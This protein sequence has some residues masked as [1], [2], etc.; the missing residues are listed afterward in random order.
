MNHSS[1]DHTASRSGPWEALLAASSDGIILLDA[2]GRV[3][4]ASPVALR[5]LGD[6]L[7][8]AYA[9]SILPPAA[10]AADGPARLQLGCTDVVVHH[11]ALGA[12]GAMLLIQIAPQS[13]ASIS[14]GHYEQK[15]YDLLM[16]ISS[17]L[18]TRTILERV[19]RLTMELIGA[20]ASSI[21]LYNAERDSIDPGWIINMPEIGISTS[22]HRGS[23]VVWDL[24]DTGCPIMINNYPG[25]PRAIPALVGAGVSALIAAPIIGVDRTIFGVIT[26]YRLAPD[27]GFSKHDVDQLVMIGRQTGI[28][29]QNARLYEDVLREAD[30]RHLLYVA[31]IEIGAALD[32]EDLYKAIHRAAARLMI[33]DTFAIALYDEERQEITYVYIADQ[34]GRW[35][36]R[37]LPVGCD[38]LG[39]VISNDISLRLGNSDAEIEALFGAERIH[40][41]ADM[42]HSILATVMHTGEQIVGAITVQARGTTA[43]TS[44]DLDVLETLA[45][46]AAIAT[47]NARLFARIQKMATIDP[48][49]Q[50]P[51]RRHFFDL[52]TREIERSDR[53]RRPLS[54][55][56]FDIDSF[57]AV[58]DTYGHLAGDQVLRAVAACCR[59]DLRDIDT[60]ARFGGE[61]FVVLLPETTYDR[62]LQVAQR[63]RTRIA[64]MLVE[65]DAGTISVTV[66]IG[67]ESCD[68]V[69]AGVLK[70]LIDRADQA[71]YVAK[72][73]GRDQVIGF[74]SL[75]CGREISRGES[76]ASH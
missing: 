73:G 29:I 52:A 61:E 50:I 55:I 26:L 67:V 28:A 65:S 1:N 68:D 45:S 58:N 30:R 32:P 18:D 33:C 53:Y 36:L 4:T 3:T 9:A 31:S 72:N 6:D 2:A 25:E 44:K 70:D 56:M 76:S 43:Y 38:L 75:V 59:D 10:L 34:Q 51:N 5:L 23:G 20:D 17:A 64:E 16:T 54:L 74:R 15:F 11:T 42:A 69:F 13:H 71:L 39:H 27:R 46:T 49:T 66:S 8:G 57:K 37:R 12:Q 24:I 60:V 21:P 41:G 48:L 7:V 40:G 19:A 63:L 62:A 35:P 47:Q 14:Y 22:Y